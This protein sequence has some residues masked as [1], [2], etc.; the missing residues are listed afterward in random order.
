MRRCGWRVNVR[1]RFWALLERERSEEFQRGQWEV[2]ILLLTWGIGR[3]S[4]SASLVMN[5]ELEAQKQNLMKRREN[6]RQKRESDQ[7]QI[8]ELEAN[9]EQLELKKQDFPSKMER[10]V[11]VVEGEN[12]SIGSLTRKLD[13]LRTEGE[14]RFPNLQQALAWYEDLLALHIDPGPQSTVRLTW[15]HL[16]ETDPSKQASISLKSSQHGLL[17][18]E[19]DP[20]IEF[21]DLLIRFNDNEDLCAFVSAL[22]DRFLSKLT[23]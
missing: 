16:V 21:E 15:T 1:C 10:L 7:N 22:R 2:D 6:L 18:T 13:F 5:Q 17:V 9:L 11:K 14:K 20:L 8:S 12:Q 19:V 4:D 3:L 23:P